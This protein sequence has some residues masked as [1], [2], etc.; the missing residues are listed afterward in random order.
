MYEKSWVNELMLRSDG[1]VAVVVVVV[2]VPPQAIRIS[3]DNVRTGTN[4]ANFILDLHVSTHFFVP[5]A[6]FP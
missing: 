4:L 5:A 3:P 6:F 1:T 2:V